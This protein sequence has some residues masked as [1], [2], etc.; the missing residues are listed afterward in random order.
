MEN[1]AWDEQDRCA[2][3]GNKIPDKKA[4][5]TA[6]IVVAYPKEK[7]DEQGYAI[8][9]PGGFTTWC[10][11]DVFEENYRLLDGQE[12]DLITSLDNYK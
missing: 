12:K 8:E 10:P 7:A 9:Y 6:K 3:C 11:K 4:Y 2:M 1:L 5:I